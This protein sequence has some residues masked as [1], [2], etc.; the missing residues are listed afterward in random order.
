MTSSQNKIEINTT[1]QVVTIAG[2]D[3]G[4]GAGIQADLKTFQARHVFGMSIV[5]ALTAQNTIGVQDSLAIPSDFISAQFDSLAADFKIKACKT[6]MLADKAHVLTVVDNLK[7]VDYGPLI[8]DPVMIAKGGH[9]LLKED[10]IDTIR[11]ELLQIAYVVTPNLPEASVLLDKDITTD[12]DIKEAAQRL[13]EMGAK[14]VIIKGGHAQSSLSKDFVLLEN[15]QAFW[16][17]SKRVDTVRTH[18]TGDTFSACIAAELAKGFSGEEAIIT[19]K[20]FIQ[21]AIS[22]SISVGHGH[23]PTNHWAELDE[24][25]TI[26]P[27]KP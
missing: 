16:L 27:V 25:I 20:K 22:Q 24:D 13:Q 14:N 6:G 11:T 21:G 23:G 5:I 2:S 18:G 7:K 19:A 4:G 3:S 12:D 10:A 15:K 17:E 8:V 9:P 26:V 1:P